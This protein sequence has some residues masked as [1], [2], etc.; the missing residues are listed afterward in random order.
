MRAPPHLVLS[1]CFALH[2]TTDLRSR[3]VQQTRSKPARMQDARNGMWAM[4]KTCMPMTGEARLD[5]AM[6]KQN[7]S[8]ASTDG[9]T[10][11]GDAHHRF[12]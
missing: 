8:G 11:R 1:F 5:R 10:L 7:V 4:R 9:E 6:L 12:V 3:S 2:S